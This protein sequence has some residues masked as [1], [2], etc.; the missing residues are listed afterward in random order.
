MPDLIDRNVP[1]L[2]RRGVL[3]A[4]RTARQLEVLHDLDDRLGHL[5]RVF[6]VADGVIAVAT[7][8]DDLVVGD[9]GADDRG[10]E[11]EGPLAGDQ[12]GSDI[13]QVSVERAQ[14]P[15]LCAG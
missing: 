10:T 5:F 11:D 14:I 12:G 4:G 15:G 6:R 7:D 3:L 1:E 8:D 9:D 2:E 13:E